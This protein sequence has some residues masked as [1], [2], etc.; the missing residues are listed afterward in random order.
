[1]HSGCR[2]EENDHIAVKYTR[3]SLLR[4]VAKIFMVYS[5]QT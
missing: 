2:V 4:I 5:K 1:M 3:F